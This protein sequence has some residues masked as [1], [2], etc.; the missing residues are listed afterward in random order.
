LAARRP[1][2]YRCRVPYLAILAAIALQTITTPPPSRTPRPGPTDTIAALSPF[3]RAKAETLLRERLPCLGCHRLGDEGGRIGPDLGTVGA[4]R[5]GAYIA[6][7]IAD[8]AHTVRGTAMPRTPMPDA[9]RSLITRYLAGRT[10]GAARAVAPASETAPAAGATTDGAEIRGD[11]LYARYCAAC[12]GAKGG[13][14][15]PNAAYLPVKPAVHASKD[16]MSKRPDDALF[17]TI[18][19]GGYVMGRSVRMPA[20]GET[21]SHAQ[22]RALVRHIRALCRCTGPSWGADATR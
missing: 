10:G 19:G 6:R 21:L 17:D 13:G 11:V 18:A 14:D 8:P 5:S 9:M 12:H 7:M 2:G 20:F 4:R 3:A 15:G 22:I 1:G 16:A